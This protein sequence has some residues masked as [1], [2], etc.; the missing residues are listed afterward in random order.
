MNILAELLVLLFSKAAIFNECSSKYQIPQNITFRCT[1]TRSRKTGKSSFLSRYMI[2]GNDIVDNQENLTL[3]IPLETFASTANI[4]LLR[5]AYEHYFMTPEYMQAVLQII[6]N[7]TDPKNWK[8]VFEQIT[9]N[10]ICG[11]SKIYYKVFFCISGINP[12]PPNVIAYAVY[13]KDYD[14]CVVVKS[15]HNWLISVREFKPNLEVPNYIA[16]LKVS[17]GDEWPGNVDKLE[18]IICSD[19]YRQFHIKVIDK[20]Y[21]LLMYKHNYDIGIW[22]GRVY[23]FTCI[24]RDDCTFGCMS[25]RTIYVGLDITVGGERKEWAIGVDNPMEWTEIRNSEEHY[26]LK[27]SFDGP[28]NPVHP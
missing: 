22:A 15:G 16:V 14:W 27:G 20:K 10:V 21:I 13:S 4:T 2:V 25:E 24:L 6:Q 18:S 19:H 5:T 9:F 1:V 17:D 11:E 28:R 12:N 7:I 3:A 23:N 26:P 8:Y